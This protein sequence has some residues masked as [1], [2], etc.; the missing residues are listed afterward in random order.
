MTTNPDFPQQ[1]EQFLLMYQ[2]VT[3][4]GNLLYK[5]P[6]FQTILKWPVTIVADDILKKK[7]KKFNIFLGK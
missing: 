2:A 3:Q 5:S 6:E 7:K 1:L 4:V